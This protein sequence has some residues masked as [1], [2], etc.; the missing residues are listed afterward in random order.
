MIHL[1][2]TPTSILLMTSEIPTYTFNGDVFTFIGTI[3]VFTVPLLLL[4]IGWSYRNS[5][6]H[7]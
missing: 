3:A 4:W 6:L 2:S 1:T 7:K 5:P